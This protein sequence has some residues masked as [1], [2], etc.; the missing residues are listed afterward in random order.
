MAAA[1]ARDD[2]VPKTARQLSRDRDR[3][4]AVW[5][6]LEDALVDTYLA[7]TNTQVRER[8]TRA[9]PVRGCPLQYHERFREMAGLLVLPDQVVQQFDEAQGRS[10]NLE[11]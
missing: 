9:V 4:R 3:Q 1:R 10:P 6:I 7:D 2:R 5:S 11:P 8:F